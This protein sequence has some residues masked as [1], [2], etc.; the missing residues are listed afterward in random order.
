MANTDSP[1]HNQVAGAACILKFHSLVAE[2]HAKVKAA[3]C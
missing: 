3:G 1:C 2:F